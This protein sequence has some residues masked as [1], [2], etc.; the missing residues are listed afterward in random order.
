M[1]TLFI[2]DDDIVFQRII[3]MTLIKYPA[4]KHVHYFTEGKSLLTYLIENK[5]DFSNL[6]DVIFLDLSMPEL[7]GW[8]VL[9]AMQ[10]FYN[11][12]CKKIAVYIVTVS[13]IARDKERALAYGFVKEFISKPL[14]GD[15]IIAIKNS[16]QYQIK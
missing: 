3:K 15:K 14:Y 10:Q 13:V 7:D 8:G 2:V 11:S 5:N 9:D 1:H 16:M 6:P 12:L 4:F